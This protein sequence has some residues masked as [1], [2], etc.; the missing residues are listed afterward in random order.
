MNSL[1]RKAVAAWAERLDIGDDQYQLADIMAGVPA[2]ERV[3]I[4]K[5]VLSTGENQ[6]KNCA[7]MVAWEW[8]A[9]RNDLEPDNAQAVLSVVPSLAEVYGFFAAHDVRDSTDVKIDFA[10]A[11]EAVIETSDLD[12][13]FVYDSST[14]EHLLSQFRGALI[15]RLVGDYDDHRKRNQWLGDNYLVLAPYAATMRAQNRADK[16]FCKSLLEVIPALSEGVL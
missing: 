7:D 4:L 16:K 1:H 14:D 6:I 10:C 15:C 12:E 9:T 5:A 13:E 11:V 3:A 2:V 8:S